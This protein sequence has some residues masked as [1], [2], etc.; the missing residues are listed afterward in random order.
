MGGG[1]RAQEVGAAGGDVVGEDVDA[2]E[3]GEGAKGLA[4]ETG[5]VRAAAGQ[6]TGGGELAAED[7]DEEVAVAAGGFK[8]AGADIGALS[9][10]QVTHIADEPIGGENLPVVPHTLAG[11]DESLFRFLGLRH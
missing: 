6:G 8:E 4:A 9:G 2:V 1:P 10:H 7:L 5:G 11:L 3:G